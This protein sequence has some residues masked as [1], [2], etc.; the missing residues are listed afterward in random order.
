MRHELKQLGLRDQRPASLPGYWK[1]LSSSLAILARERTLQANCGAKPSHVS[2]PE[3]SWVW[4]G[5]V[6]VFGGGFF[7]LSSVCFFFWR[8]TVCPRRLSAHMG[9]VPCAPYPPPPSAVGN[10]GVV[11]CGRCSGGGLEEQSVTRGP[12]CRGASGAQ[13]D[14]VGVDV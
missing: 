9:H 2:F 10:P 5:E 3:L 6:V 1:P 14:V 7:L 13:M 8:Q 12:I 4:C 11:R